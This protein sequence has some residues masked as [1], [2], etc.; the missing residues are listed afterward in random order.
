MIKKDLLNENH[1]SKDIFSLEE[2][3]RAMPGYTQ[4]KP[5][6]TYIPPGLVPI[7]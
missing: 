1:N 6:V 2:R 5:L 7:K 4:L 3:E